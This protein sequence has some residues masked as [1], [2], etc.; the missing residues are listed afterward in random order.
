MQSASRETRVDG[1][2][3]VTLDSIDEELIKLL[4]ADGRAA[5]A[6]LG[7]RVE[8]SGDAVRERLKRLISEDVIKVVGSVSAP[9]L[10]LGS[11]AL[12]GITANG[13]VQPIA[14]ALT[15]LPATDLVVQTAGM[16]DIIAELVGRDDR[17]ILQVLDESVRTIPEVGRCL[18]M[19]YLS[20]EKY[21]AGGPRQILLGGGRHVGSPKPEVREDLDDAD[22][23]LAAVL[24]QDGRASY[25]QLAEQS[26]VPYASARRRV[27]RL[28]ERGVVRI[29]TVTNQI[30]FSHRVQAGIG[31][32]V[33]GP[34]P[35]AVRQLK[36]LPEVEVVVATT[37]PYD[38]L[39]EASCASRA[40]LYDLT[41][42]KLRSVPGVMSTETFNYINIHKLPYT[43]ADL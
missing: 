20:V 9:T 14:R 30:L 18:V 10:G 12:V 42:T 2:R 17:E 38:L 23:A 19:Q 1:A 15:E 31:V 24:Q 8:L 28:L 3:G 35:E 34:I 29:V 41:G 27:V 13:P 40:D 37:G 33:H 16:F 5:Y 7:A 36:E 32:R 21:A 22:R 4:V 39:I 6:D 11:F 25:R 43:W 26:G